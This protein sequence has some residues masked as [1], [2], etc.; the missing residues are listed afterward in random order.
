[1][2]TEEIGKIQTNNSQTT[3]KKSNGKNQSNNHQGKHNSQVS[4]NDRNDENL[5]Q[6]FK[7]VAKDLDTKLESAV[8]II[9]SRISDLEIS[10]VGAN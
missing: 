1:M 10:R 4:R 3:S 2:S 5:I 7:D 9:N 6:A 8:K